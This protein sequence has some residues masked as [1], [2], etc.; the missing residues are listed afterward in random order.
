[1][2]KEKEATFE[3]RASACQKADAGEP[4]LDSRWRSRKSTKR[5][6][7]SVQKVSNSFHEFFLS[8]PITRPNAAKVLRPMD[9]SGRRTLRFRADRQQSPVASSPKRHSWLGV[10]QPALLETPASRRVRGEK[11]GG[12]KSP[13]V[14]ELISEIAG[15]VRWRFNY[16][17]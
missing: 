7:R 11:R 2:E 16:G 1:M 14:A 13:S 17:S 4:R 6:F 5:L 8:Q 12:A 3:A 10:T 15:Q 9:R